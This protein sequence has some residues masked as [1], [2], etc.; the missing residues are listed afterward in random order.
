MRIRRPAT[1][2]SRVHTYVRPGSQPVASREEEQETTNLIRLLARCY[3][4]GHLASAD[5]LQRANEDPLL[6][7]LLPNRALTVTGLR[8]FRLCH[9][10]PLVRELARTLATQSPPPSAPGEDAETMAR[11]RIHMARLLDVGLE[12]D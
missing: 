2:A 5:V 9:Q 7:R 1:T 12:D 8:R 6:L 10:M 11:D 3:A 4:E